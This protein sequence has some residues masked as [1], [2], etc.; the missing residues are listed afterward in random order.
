MGVFSIGVG[1][2]E[3][4]GSAPRRR[5][6]LLRYA[7]AVL[8]VA[9]TVPI[10]VW[11]RPFSYSSPY[12]YFYPAIL[13]ALWF[14]ELGPSLF[15]TV[16]SGVAVNYFLFLPHNQF[17]LDAGS[18]VRTV[19]FCG[20]VGTMCWFIDRNRSRA[21]IAELAL[22]KSREDLLASEDRLAKIMNS[23]MDAIITLEQDQRIVVFNAAAEK[24]FGCPRAEALGH[25]VDRFIPE[26]VR[27]VHRD[28]VR[29]FGATFVTTRSMN[30]PGTLYGLRA[31][32]EEFPLEATIS[33]VTVKGQK[34]YTVILRDITVR[35]KTEAA[36]IRSEKLALVGRLTATIAHEISNPLES[37]HGLLYLAE[38]SRSQN[39]AIEYLKMIQAEVT[40]ATQI[41]QATLG[42]CRGGE[43]AKRFRPTEVLD[44]ILTLIDRKLRT[45]RIACEREYL[46]DAEISGVEGEIRQVLWNLPN[47]S[48][49][50][51]P[52]GGHIKI[53][54]SANLRSVNEPGVRIS[55]AD[56]GHG[57]VANRVSLLFEPF[58]T[59]KPDG[60]GLGLW[61]VSELIKK[62]KGSVRVRSRTNP[63]EHTGTVFLVFLPAEFAKTQVDFRTASVTSHQNMVA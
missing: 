28:H 14:G 21:E 5:S 15:A 46:T 23:A 17:S 45:K 58:Y 18:V 3:L 2:C 29:N 6:A 48:V 10:C 40:R 61:V 49:D 1:Q 35:K 36:L 47:N 4:F 56:D 37:I 30:S 55:I 32:G 39:E 22:G 51:V 8:L 25:P 31:N 12:L 19:I 63:K 38:R 52:E 11:L 41:A 9:A 54:V 20:S 13:I 50:A 33:Q 24:V 16:L 42:F 59:T 44:S 53:R 62:H 34:L 43:T 27:D 26:R 7:V 60:N 57:I